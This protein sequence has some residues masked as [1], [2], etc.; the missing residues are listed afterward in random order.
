MTINSGEGSKLRI[1]LLT[2]RFPY[3]PDKGDRIRSYHWLKAL[4]TQ[5]DV[6]VLTLTENAVPEP[7]LREVEKLA[8]QVRVVTSSPKAK[9]WCAAKAF[10][11]GRSL[12]ESYLIP[13]GFHER[14]EEL[15]TAEKYDLCLA[16]CSSMGSI[17]LKDER[18]GR[19]IVDL[20][21]V[22]SAKWRMYGLR[23]HGLQKWAFNRESKKIARLER[24]LAERAEVCVTV[25]RRECE[26]LR[27]VAP[28]V[29]TLA[30]PNG[31]DTEYFEPEENQKNIERIVF[32]G[33]MDYFPNVDAVKWFA[34]NVWPAITNRHSELQWCIV[35]RNPTLAVRNLARLRNVSVTGEVSDVRPFLTS[36]ISIAPLR[37]ACGVQNKVLEAM[38][39]GRP[40]VTTSEVAGGIEVTPQEEFLIANDPSEWIGAIDL[41]LRDSEFCQKLGTRARRAMVDHFTWN[42][43]ADQM[44]N[45]AAGD[46]SGESQA[47]PRLTIKS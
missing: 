15:L 17:M 21:D 9:W 44:L 33:Q 26:L 12:T 14:F 4:S 34:E 46:R 28:G 23:H 6:D 45:C 42:T 19:L 29:S 38:S 36:A 43:V 13:R 32:V 10:F 20:V 5:H 25:S 30:I 8:R 7:F 35:G 40:M 47:K 11:T 27:A 22:D 41:L 24:Q 2:H 18:V 37:L 1:L 3:P 39:A 16:V 31:V